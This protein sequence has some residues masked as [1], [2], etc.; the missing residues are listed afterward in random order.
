LHFLHTNIFDGKDNATYLA[1]AAHCWPIVGFAGCFGFGFL[2]A[3]CEFLMQGK[4]DKAARKKYRW[5]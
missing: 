4:C 3:F 1:A 5:L 2:E